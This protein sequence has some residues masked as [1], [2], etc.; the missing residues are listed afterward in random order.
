MHFSCLPV[1]NERLLHPLCVSFACYFFTTGQFNIFVRNTLLPHVKL[2]EEMLR[3]RSRCF[4]VQV[5]IN[6]V[7]VQNVLE[8]A[9]DLEE[10]DVAEHRE[11]LRRAFK[12]A[13]ICTCFIPPLYLP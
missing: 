10:R 4:H 2:P 13:A 11:F 3:I 6:A 8:E 7:Q 1:H 12:R 5:A 9:R